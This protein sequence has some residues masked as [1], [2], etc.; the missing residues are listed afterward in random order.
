MD[1]DCAAAT[2]NAMLIFAGRYFWLPTFNAAL[3][4]SGLLGRQCCPAYYSNA[5]RRLGFQ[6]CLLLRRALRSGFAGA[7]GG[8]ASACFFRAACFHSARMSKK[9]A[10]RCTSKSVNGLLS[11]GKTG[12]MDFAAFGSGLVATLSCSH[13]VSGLWLLG[14]AWS[15]VRPLA[16]FAGSGMAGPLWKIGS[17]RRPFK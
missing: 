6:S 5:T 14:V 2:T 8:A 9:A 17:R 1:S 7:V 13:L 10:S 4:C 11:R 3:G 15:G 12:L 16:S